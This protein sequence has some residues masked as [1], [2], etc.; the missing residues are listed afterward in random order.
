MTENENSDKVVEKFFPTGFREY[1][2][3]YKNLGYVTFVMKK[4][5]NSIFQ[6]VNK[7]L[8]RNPRP[9]D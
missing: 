1:P 8:K 4:G 9:K 7:I 2:A 6:R 3:M 5:I